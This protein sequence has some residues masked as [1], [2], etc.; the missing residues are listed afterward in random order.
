MHSP[1]TLLRAHFIYVNKQYSR[2]CFPHEEFFIRNRYFFV[3]KVK[4]YQNEMSLN[5]TQKI[6]LATHQLVS[7]IGYYKS[8]Y[9]T[10]K[11]TLN[12]YV[13]IKPGAVSLRRL[14]KIPLVLYVGELGGRTQ[15]ENKYFPTK[16]WWRRSIRY[17]RD[18]FTSK[19]SNGDWIDKPR[20]LSS[21]GPNM[22]RMH[23]ARF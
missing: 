14:V 5:S 20:K 17:G 18:Y 16:R 4:S 10:V 7:I 22:K 21:D 2:H 23:L 11:D 19:A 9:I 8:E 6:L 3:S 12:I 15:S 13:Y 1:I